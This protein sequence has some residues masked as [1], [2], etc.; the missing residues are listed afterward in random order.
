M[1]EL[2]ERRIA[3]DDDLIPGKAVGELPFKVPRAKSYRIRCR[4]VFERMG[5]SVS[6][7]VEL[8][9]LKSTHKIELLARASAK[10]QEIECI[11]DC[12]HHNHYITDREVSELAVVVQDLGA[13]RGYLFSEIGFRSEAIRMALRRGVTLTSVSDFDTNAGETIA[14]SRLGRLKRLIVGLQSGIHSEFSEFDGNI[15]F[16]PAIT[17]DAR[18][19]IFAKAIDD[20]LNGI[21]P[22]LCEMDDGRPRFA[23]CSEDVLQHGESIVRSIEQW[24]I[25]KGCR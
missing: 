6:T 19:T 22:C 5:F 15:L 7:N 3:D 2:Q 14:I 25:I 4:E 21:F 8:K 1:Y 23:H 16:A 20:C 17:H 18:L 24:K 9:G 11:V 12:S 13:V 10:S